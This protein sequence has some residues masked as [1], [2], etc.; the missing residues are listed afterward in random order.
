[1]MLTV[2]AWLTGSK[3]GRYVAG[4]G[5][6][7]VIVSVVLWRTFAAGKKSA[8]LDQKIGQLDALREKVKTDEEIRDMSAAERRE[9]LAKW[10]RD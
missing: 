1:M 8:E 5:I 7:A 3:I 2:L 4:A 10:V 9:Q 6:V